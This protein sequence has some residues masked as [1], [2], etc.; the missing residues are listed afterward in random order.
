[1]L[2]NTIGL[3]TLAATV[4]GVA[5]PATFSATAA[6]LPATK[7]N[8]VVAPPATT[9]TRV[10]F[11]PQPQLQLLDASGQLVA[12]GGVT[13]TATITGTGNS[14]VSGTAT[15][16]TAA[17]GIATFSSLGA[18]GTAGAKILTF[19]ATG[20]I[21]ATANVTVTPGAAA[22]LAIN[23]GNNQ[24]VPANSVAPVSPSVLVADTDGNPIANIPVA[25]AVTAGG[26]FISNGS[27]LSDAS[28][29]ARVNTWTV[30]PDGAQSVT[31]TAVGLSGSPAVFNATATNPPASCGQPAI[32]N[33]GFLRNGALSS[34]PCTLLDG[35]GQMILQR[36]F[37][38]P[39]AG[40]TYFY[41]RYTITVPAQTIVRFTNTD[42]FTSGFIYFAAY[43]MDNT[44]VAYNAVSDLVVNNASL[45]PVQYQIVVT[46]SS[47]GITG[48]YTIRPFIP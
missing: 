36:A 44:W 1:L 26:G 10:Q 41:D 35:P 29:I 34:S 33:I 23:T 47:P 42:A 2:G 16:T 5:S 17:N 24:N 32:L 11:N 13:V 43:R 30:G 6:A 27:A 21:S 40:G 48:A 4:Q 15:A 39:Q 8:I 25:F 38:G 45:N 28:G 37:T 14:S 20:L 12:Q 3:Q 18:A 46:T 19:S 7:L 31:A 22:T 9:V